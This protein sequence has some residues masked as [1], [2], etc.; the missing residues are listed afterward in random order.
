ME[1]LVDINLDAAIRHYKNTLRCTKEYHKKNPEKIKKIRSEYYQRV[2]LDP[3]RN[4]KLLET[5]RFH[6][7]KYYQKN[8]QKKENMNSNDERTNAQCEQQENQKVIN[9]KTNNLGSI[10]ILNYMS[11][12]NELKKDLKENKN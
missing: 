2:K 3:I 9:I 5:Q 6:S 7:R 12:W 11:N 4:A 8:V 1:E 10:S